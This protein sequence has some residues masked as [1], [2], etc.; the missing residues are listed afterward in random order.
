[1]RRDDTNPHLLHSTQLLKIGTN[2]ACHFWKQRQPG[3]HATFVDT[4]SGA[5]VAVAFSA[6]ATISVT[7]ARSVHAMLQKSGSELQAALA[8]SGVLKPL[9]GNQSSHYLDVA[10]FVECFSSFHFVFVG[11]EARRI[12]SDYEVLC[13]C[14]LFALHAD[15]PCSQ[16]VRSLPWCCRSPDIVLHPYQTRK[17]L[18]SRGNSAQ[19]ATAS[20]TEVRK[21]LRQKLLQECLKLPAELEE[22]QDA[23]THS[24]DSDNAKLKKFRKITK[25]EGHWVQ[26]ESC[27]T[28]R[29]TSKDEHDH[30]I[31]KP[32]ACKFIGVQCKH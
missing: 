30:Y 3:N 19:N 29:K 24:Q 32:F 18:T 20:K 26:C 13:T 9:S 8:A 1:M 2:P 28:W 6:N 7:K 27:H 11:D 16:F 21:E 10:A 4:D 22:L 23:A 5:A 14:M 25:W 17:D 15:C 12:R 31:G